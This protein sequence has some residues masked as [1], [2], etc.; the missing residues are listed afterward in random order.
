M[1]IL[2]SDFDGTIYFPD[3][4][5]KN[6][7][8]V[9]SIRNFILKGNIFCIITGRNYSDIKLLLNKYNIPYSYLICEDGAKIFNNMDY[10][11]DTIYLDKDTIENVIPILDENKFNY[12]LDDGYN[13]TNN[14]NDCVKIVV[15]CDNRDLQKKI[16]NQIRKK[17]NVHVYA[18]RFHVNIIEASVNKASALKRLLNIENFSY[19]DFYVI[20]DNDNDYEML[21]SFT[22]A[23]IKKHHSCLDN[24]KKKE[25]DELNQY[26]FDLLKI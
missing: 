6:I 8:N 13:E 4:S 26:I 18:S 19:N 20:G 1:K 10:C 7:R 2:A 5:E 12:Y 9:N 3:D 15:N 17:V 23:V 16:I 11:M 21:K 25:Y 14:L 22:G 24:L